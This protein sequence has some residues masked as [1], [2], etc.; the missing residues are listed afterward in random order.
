M[1]HPCQ[2]L[3]PSSLDGVAS[4]LEWGGRTHNI[5]LTCGGLYTWDD[6]IDGIGRL[7]TQ[8]GN[9]D[10]LIAFLPSSPREEPGAWR[11]V[12]ERLD[13]TRKCTTTQ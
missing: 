6:V 9:A 4:R 12:A 8:N 13:T 7:G 11:I 10:R 3:E 2:K 5:P 1:A